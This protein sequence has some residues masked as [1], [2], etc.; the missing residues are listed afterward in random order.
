MARTGQQVP[1]TLPVS[2]GAGLKSMFIR[3][4]ED[5]SVARLSLGA[6]TCTPQVKDKFSIFKWLEKKS[7]EKFVTCKKH[8]KL[9][10]QCS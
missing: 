2:S 6:K 9:K 10:A 7:K 4:L 5:S 8:M 3:A 1:L